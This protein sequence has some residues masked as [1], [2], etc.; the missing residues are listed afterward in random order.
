MD[1][2]ELWVSPERG[3]V[4]R[5]YVNLSVENVTLLGRPAPVSG[6]LILRYDTSAL[7]LPNNIS[8]PYGC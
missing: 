8:I 4:V 6:S 1:S 7:G 2:A 3:V 5:F